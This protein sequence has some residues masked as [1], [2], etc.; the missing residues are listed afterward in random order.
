MNA[1][2]QLLLQ[3]QQLKTLLEEEQ[4]IIINNDGKRLVEIVTQKEKMIEELAKV[5]E[6]DVEVE[7]LKSLS[8]EIK[9]LQETNLILT[10]QSLSFTDQVLK[11]IQQNATKSNTYSKKG[12]THDKTDPALLDQSL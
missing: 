1:T 10:K 9:E 4:S 8:Y 7:K 3:M 5:E 12:S 6:E 2:E 11:T